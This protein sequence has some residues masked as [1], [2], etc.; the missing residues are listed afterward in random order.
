[1][2]PQGLGTSITTKDWGERS[3]MGPCDNLMGGTDEEDYIRTLITI[4]S[5]IPYLVPRVQ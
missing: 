1:M 3:I 5:R 2:V 4:V